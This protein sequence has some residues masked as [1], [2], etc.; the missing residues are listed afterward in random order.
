M[1]GHSFG[2]LLSQKRLI[3]F[4]ITAEQLARQCRTTKEII[5]ALEADQFAELPPWPHLEPVLRAM[6]EVL[7]M[8]REEFIADFLIE[9]AAHGYQ[10][11]RSHEPM[12]RGTLA[13]DPGAITTRRVPSAP[14]AVP[15]PANKP[16]RRQPQGPP[17]PWRSIAA[18]MAVM[19]VLVSIGGISYYITSLQDR[20][21]TGAHTLNSTAQLNQNATRVE[22]IAKGRVRVKVQVEGQGSR[23][24]SMEAGD[25]GQWVAERLEVSADIPDRILLRI[26]G[27]HYRLSEP[28][29]NAGKWAVHEGKVHTLTADQTI[30]RDV[31]VSDTMTSDGKSGAGVV[32]SL[33]TKA[34]EAEAPE[35]DPEVA[36]LQREEALAMYISGSHE[37]DQVD[38]GAEEVGAAE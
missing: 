3:I 19:S 1:H 7:G 38:A 6:A 8:P 21:L 5:T 13:L 22:V 25:S 2:K 14:A 36:A 16:Y 24:M 29:L 9:A 4:G 33:S 18:S 31:Q 28:E 32:A 37:D 11:K 10:A 27:L 23:S 34:A 12:D 26:N 20:E 30:F 15:P 17:L 35:V